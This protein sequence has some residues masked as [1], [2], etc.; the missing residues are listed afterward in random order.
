VKVLAV[1][2]ARGGS[3][4]IPRKNL[5]LVSGVP[6]VVHSI[7]H[8]QQSSLVTRVLVS[9]EDAEIAD[10]A[11][12]A[13]ADV[14]FMRP[15]ALAGDDVLD[16]PVFQHV[17]EELK[18]SEN[19]V[20]DVVVHLRPTAPFRRAD[21]IDSAVRLLEESPD[22]DAVRSVSQ[23]TQHPYRM[24]RIDAEGFLDPLMKSEHPTPFLIRRQE[25]A[26]IYYYDCVLDV[27]RPRTILEMGSM[28]GER[29]LP[30]ILPADLVF[31]VDTP[32][33][34]EVARFLLERLT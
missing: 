25:L 33:D 30:Y 28:T 11:K 7:R 3:K 8:A 34:L 16:Q 14:P 23:C 20:P 22:A 5:A 32:R 12:A 13:G 19:Y 4:G 18:A 24:F 26:P 21:W 17:L 6:L 15:P 31:D 27:T 9:T 29:L 10:I 1:V 2:P